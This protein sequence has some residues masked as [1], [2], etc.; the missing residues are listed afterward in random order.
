MVLIIG[1]RALLLKNSIYTFW[2]TSSL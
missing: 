1:M 2:D